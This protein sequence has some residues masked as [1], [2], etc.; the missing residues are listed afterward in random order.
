VDPDVSQEQDTDGSVEG[1]DEGLDGELP[2]A[3]VAEPDARAA[4][5]TDLDAARDA[6]T[7]VDASQD[8]PGDAASD[9]GLPDAASDAG[10]PDAR[11]P[12]P[13]TTELTDFCSAFAAKSYAR[14][15]RCQPLLY[16]AQAR[17]TVVADIVQRCVG[18]ARDLALGRFAFDAAAA[19]AC[20]DEPDPSSCTRFICPNVLKPTRAHG[21][22]CFGV[23]TDGIRLLSSAR[24]DC[25]HGYCEQRNELCA[26]VCRPRAS[27]G[28]CS[29][30][31]ACE[32]GTSC[33]Y[34]AR[35]TPTPGAGQSC[36][37]SDCAEGL[38]CVVRF[39]G[40]SHCE[41]TETPPAPSKLG[42]RCDLACEWGSYCADPDGDGPQLK[43]CLGAKPDGAECNNEH[44]EECRSLY[45]VSD[46]SS[47]PGTCTA[48]PAEGEACN[49]SDPC[50]AGL[51]CMA[52]NKCHRAG[53]AGEPCGAGGDANCKAGLWCASGTWTC[54]QP[55]NEGQPCKRL[56]AS[57]RPGLFCACTDDEDDVSCF[58]E[59][60]GVC[61]RLLA[62]GQRCKE[63]TSCVSNSCPDRQCADITC[64]RFD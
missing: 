4:D 43:T 26:G 53:D 44:D 64:T 21:A 2:D 61:R 60:E 50:L 9:T 49:G 16:P 39:G 13:T 22:A 36:L 34:D 54:E 5:A 45:C 58:T 40:G 14:L 32:A 10:L 38:R 7:L 42:E 24:S 30:S 41:A 37:Q 17:V 3:D 33:S 23:S 52:D 6:A 15:T 46:Y 8:A 28:P 29:N 57:C 19:R 27:D 47:P 62:A 25:A 20:L 11:L 51:T 35:C 12:P 1:A 48:R 63:N 31:D 55:R 59:P 56:G 18:V